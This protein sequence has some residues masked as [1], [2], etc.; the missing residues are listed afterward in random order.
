MP[1]HNSNLRIVL[2]YGFISSGLVLYLVVKGLLI[3][4]PISRYDFTF[5]II[6]L[7][8]TAVLL[9][10]L[11][12]TNGDPLF[13]SI[14]KKVM[15]GAAA[16][17]VCLGLCIVTFNKGLG[18]FLAWAASGD[19]RNH[20]QAIYSLSSQGFISP[21][22]LSFPQ[23]STTISTFLNSGMLTYLGENSRERLIGDLTSYAL[24]WLLAISLLGFSF[25]SIWESTLD[26]QASLIQ[27]SILVP[28]SLIAI[29]S[30]ALGTNLRGGF[31][32]ASAASISVAL[33][34]GLL[35]DSTV[36]SS[37]EYVFVIVVAILLAIFSWTLII[38]AV[39]FLLLPLIWNWVEYGQGIYRKSLKLTSILLLL[40]IGALAYSKTFATKL[41]EVVNLSG[42]IVAMDPRF[43]T[44]AIVVLLT[45][46]LLSKSVDSSWTLKTLFVGSA[47]LA[48]I[49]LLKSI[50]DLAYG[51]WNYY[52]LKMMMV[53]FIGF[54]PAVFIFVPIALMILN[55]H[56]EASGASLLA[57][58]ASITILVFI[59]TELI[60]PIPK[61]LASMNSGWVKPDP[62]SLGLVLEQ[63]NDPENPTVLFGWNPSDPDVTRMANFWLG[64]YAKPLVPFQDWSNIQNPE[65]DVLIFCKLN[66][67]YPSMTVLTRNQ[68][69]QKSMNNVCPNEKIKVLYQEE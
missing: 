19:S 38:L 9:R 47:G 7:V 22:S 50:S 43:Y 48:S 27:V 59:G 5:S 29:S 64:A 36:K 55:K 8:S 40:S 15:A 46:T 20:V 61:A 44:V 37:G 67:A 56:Y 49:F 39:F 60:S 21:E 51:D 41:S 14:D 13:R 23:L 34:V 33:A 16:F 30:I 11:M 17:F 32:S 62:T 45:L 35:F 53:I 26:E 42:S 4:T 18:H 57:A 6:L 65:D 63:D 52:T 2:A 10:C 24:T 69:L 58:H 31:I 68:E 3:Q 66:E 28:A 54:L 1:S 12:R 25:A